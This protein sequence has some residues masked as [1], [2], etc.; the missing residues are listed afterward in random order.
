MKAQREHTDMAVLFLYPRRL[1]GL[2]GQLHAR[3]LYLR[4]R[5]SIPIVQETGW[6]T[7]LVRTGAENLAPTGIRSRTVQLAAMRQTR[8]SLI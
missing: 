7:E 4:E 5:K 6:A 1:V 8:V 3:Q 2:S